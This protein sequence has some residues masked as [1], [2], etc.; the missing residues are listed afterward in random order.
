MSDKWVNKI[1][2][3]LDKAEGTSFSAERD[4]LLEKADELMVKYSVEEYQIEQARRARG[5]AAVLRPL[6]KDVVIPYK[7]Q[8]DS[9]GDQLYYLLIYIA[10]A[11]GVR[12]LYRRTSK[13]ESGDYGLGWLITLVGFEQDV[14]Y[15]E[16]LYLTLRLQLVKS[17]EPEVDPAL[18]YDA[19]IYVLH[20]AGVKWGE[21]CRLL[22]KVAG[23]D[24][25]PVT[26]WPDGG[27]IHRAYDRECKARG[28]SGQAIYSHKTY[29]RSFAD[30]F[31]SRIFSRLLAKRGD[32]QTALVLADK[33]KEVDDLW[34]SLIP[35]PAETEEQ[36]K[37][38]KR[39]RKVKETPF[40]PRAYDAGTAVA[41]KVDLS[42][43]GERVDAAPKQSIK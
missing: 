41:D 20:E 38:S 15:V 42:T 1:Q 8:A 14:N 6:T 31:N 36:P 19:N 33:A 39:V 24:T 16:M 9:Y 7:S 22:N 37:Q 26:P 29:R 35:K 23:E 40:N 11:V 2:A 43:M 4:A 28:V 25:W 21:I 30:G 18:G 12:T 17:L 3:L 13:H 5:E 34:E 27:K 10:Q 32:A